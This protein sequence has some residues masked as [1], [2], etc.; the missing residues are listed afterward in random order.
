M[1]IWARIWR[2]LFSDSQCT[3]DIISAVH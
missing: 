3:C 2:Q 1:K